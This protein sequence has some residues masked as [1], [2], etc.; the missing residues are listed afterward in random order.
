MST[1]Q[2][3]TEQRKWMNTAIALLSMIVGYVFMTFFGQLGEWF[4]LE[5]KIS[6]YTFVVQGVAVVVGVET[7]VF[8]SKYRQT[9]DY[10][11]E[12]FG[13]LSKVVWPDKNSNVRHTIG[14]I[15]GVGIVGFLLGLFDFGVSRLLNLIYS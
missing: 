12:V 9:A 15:I 13:E 4:E 1:A 11:Q 6:H 2:G 14:I 8:I 10:I 5:S 3:S 7:F